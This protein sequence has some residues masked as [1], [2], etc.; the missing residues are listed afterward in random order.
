M[1]EIVGFICSEC[2]TKHKVFGNLKLNL[3]MNCDE[4]LAYSTKRGDI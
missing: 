4:I 1:I 2:N 3:C